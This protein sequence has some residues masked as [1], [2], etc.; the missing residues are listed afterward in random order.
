MNPNYDIIEQKRIEELDASGTLYKHKKSGAGIFVIHNDDPNKTFSISFRTPPN[1]HTGLAHILE[2]SVLCGSR[3]FPIKDPFVELAKGSL[4]TFLNA[5]TFSDKTMYPIASCND[6]DFENLMDVY[7]DAVF[8]PNI[9]HEDKI[10]KQEG[11]HYELTDK[12]GEIDYRGVVYNEMKGVF[13]SPEQ[14]L[15]RQIQKSLFPD[16]PYA[17]ESGGDPDDIV[18]LT[19]EDFLDFHKKYYHPSNSFIFLYGDLDVQ[20]KLDWLDGMYLKDFDAIEVDSQIQKQKPFDEIK[21]LTEVYPITSDESIE[22]KTY[23]ALNYATGEAT[24]PMDYVGLEVLEYLL[25]EAPGAPLKKALQDAG[26]GKDQFGSF[27]NSILQP[28]FSIVV[29]NSDVT[30]KELFLEIVHSTLT[31]L[32][33]EGIDEKK[34]RAAINYFEFKIREADYGRYPKGIIY[35]M[36]A[37][38]SWLYGAGPYVHF[39]YNAV[40]EALKAGIEQGLFTNMI[41]KYLLNNSHGTL[42]VLIPDPQILTQKEAT[43][44]AHLAAYKNR[45]T[46]EEL[47]QMIAETKSLEDFQNQEE[48]K[49]NLESIPLLEVSDIKK[50]IEVL[51]IDIREEKLVKLVSHE[52]FTQDIVYLKL[53]FDTKMVPFEC[54]PYLGLMTGLFGEMNT[55]NYEYGDLASEVNIHTG[56]IGFDVRVYGINGSMSEFKPKFEISGKCF[57]EKVPKIFELV[58]EMLFETSFADSSRLKEILSETKSRLQM[59]LASSGHSSAAM[60]AESYYSESGLYQDEISGI[61]YYDFISAC[62]TDFDERQTEIMDQLTQ[63]MHKIFRPENLVVGVTGDMAGIKRVKKELLKFTDNLDCA[64]K[65]DEP[66]VLRPLKGNEGFMT[67]GKVQYVA[68]SG[69]FIK[70]QYEFS[71]HLHVLQTILSLDYLWQNVRVKGGAYGCMVSFKRNGNLTVVSYRDPNLEETLQIYDEMASFVNLFEAQE[72]EMRKYI[73]GTISRMD[74]P[75]TSSMKNDRILGQYFSQIT[76]E[77]RQMERDEILGTRDK[78]IRKQAK[79]IKDSL[80]QNNICAVGNE[81]K[82][83]THEAAFFTTRKLFV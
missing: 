4:N 11:W 22:E 36:R 26:V 74:Q 9:Y 24:N 59:T 12:T 44:K 56:G 25:L 60:R 79:L 54:L 16:T 47:D 49:T 71:G 45:L 35:G 8:Y 14:I 39:E 68:K 32:V 20:Q 29:K 55:T 58:Q 57:S 41:K 13:S 64:Q 40:F 17:F 31:R 15:F 65:D 78:D 72:R 5:M 83:K 69:N 30:D 82:I 66:I 81:N 51:P 21:E 43:L 23:M 6:K 67:S 61:A 38:D 73:I 34:I 76:D 27:D 10:L 7:L 18:N 75:L 1:D 28:T 3:K 53:C 46:D 80:K 63:V 62:E 48:T 42:I 37:M 70:A 50:E 77:Q 33:E 2:H 19:Q 52:T